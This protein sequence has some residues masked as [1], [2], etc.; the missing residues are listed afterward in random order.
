MT[1]LK[2]KFENVKDKVIGKTK[3]AV[4]KST[5]SQELELKGKLQ[6][7]KA[8]LKETFEGAKENIAEKINDKLDEKK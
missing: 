4:G 2:D 3:E 8:D 6:S 5:G 7:K 1:D